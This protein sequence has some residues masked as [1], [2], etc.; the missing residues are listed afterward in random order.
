MQMKRW[1]GQQSTFIDKDKSVVNPCNNVAITNGS[2][3]STTLEVVKS[4]NNNN[5]NNSRN[6]I[7]TDEDVAT[8]VRDDDYQWP[9]LYDEAHDMMMGTCCD[10]RVLCCLQK[11]LLPVVVVVASCCMLL[12]GII[13]LYHGSILSV[14]TTSFPIF[15]VVMSIIADIIHC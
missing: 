15:V 13:N 11:T 7:I 12:F 5:D 6:P 8:S 4:S 14:G 9:S 10:V 3:S 1:I 2:L